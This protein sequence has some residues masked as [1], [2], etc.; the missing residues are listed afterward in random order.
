MNWFE[1]WQ[2]LPKLIRFVVSNA[3]IGL[4]L[5]WFIVFCTIY[6]DFGRMGTLFANSDHQSAV[7]ALLM[8]SFGSTFSAA[9]VAT[10]VILIPRDEDEF[11]KL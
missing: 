8:I 2:Q 11:N 9:Y 6:F 5:G 10:A 4:A 7:I 3:V 1:K